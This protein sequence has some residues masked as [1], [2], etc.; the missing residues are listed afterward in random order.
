[1]SLVQQHQQQDSLHLKEF[2]LL[3]MPSSH[4]FCSAT[5]AACPQQRVLADTLLF[6]TC[7]NLAEAGK[8]RQL[9]KLRACSQDPVPSVFQKVARFSRCKCSW[10]VTMHEHCSIG[11]MWANSVCRSWRA[12]CVDQFV[13]T[14]VNPLPDKRAQL[15]GRST[16]ARA[17][18]QLSWTI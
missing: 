14:D 9:V 10:L 2:L 11:R 4:K 15:P 3:H 12:A 8:G 17:T 1:M 5:T 6:M 7:D 16:S 13:G 18:C